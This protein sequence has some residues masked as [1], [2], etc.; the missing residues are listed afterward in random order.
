M[1]PLY[2]FDTPSIAIGILI[3]QDIIAV[4][5]MTASKGEL[6]SL[7]ALTVFLLIPIRPVLQKVME[8]CGH[9]ELQVMFGLLVPIIG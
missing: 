3:M 1:C 5:F 4:I 2:N 7:W 9:G 8:R 6:P